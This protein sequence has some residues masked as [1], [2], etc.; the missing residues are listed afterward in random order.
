MSDNSEFVAKIKAGDKRAFSR[1]YKQTKNK[2]IQYVYTKVSN[3]KDCEEIVQ[4]SYLGFLDSVPLFR[5]QSSLWTFLVSI[6]RHEIADY[7]RRKY[8]KKALTYVPFIDMGYTED[9]YSAKETREHC[10]H[11]LES[12]TKENKMLII[13]KYMDKLPVNEIAKKLDISPK[14]AESRLFRA[15]KA[16]QVAYLEIES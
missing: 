5:G 16:F 15:R 6:T 4:D 3:P 11:V 1:F 12:L 10:N 14:A 9:V 2:L 7:Y 8:A 13:W